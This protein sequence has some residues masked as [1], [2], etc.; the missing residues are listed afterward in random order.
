MATQNVNNNLKEIGYSKWALYYS[1]ILFAISAIIGIL[2]LA[3][4]IY[5]Y[6]LETSK[7]G[8]SVMKAAKLKWMVILLIVIANIILLFLGIVLLYDAY[9]RFPMLFSR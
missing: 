2:P 5:V 4:A 9:N 1:L 7:K 6:Y 3:A 8:N